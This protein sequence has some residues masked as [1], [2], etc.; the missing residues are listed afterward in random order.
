MRNKG[1]LM[2]G[3]IMLY[4]AALIVINGSAVSVSA[5]SLPV[6]VGDFTCISQL[7]ELP[8]G[9]EITAMTMLL[10]Y[11]G[12][13]M[14]KEM[15]AREYLPVLKEFQE[16]TARSGKHG[17][18]TVTYGSDLENYFLGDPFTEYGTV[19]GTSAIVMAANLYLLETE[20]ELWAVDRSGITAKELYEIVL[21]GNPAVVF[22][23]IDMEDRTETM[24]WYTEDGTYVEWSHNDH[25]TVIIG[26]SEQKVV[27]ADPLKGIVTYDKEQFEKIFAQ[28]GYR[29]VVIKE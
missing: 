10:N 19:C 7:P 20:R 5:K 22:T 8:T 15:M 4:M 16:G 18:G 17:R 23:T 9:C 26:C 29:C 27:I 6:T 21:A 24:G 12:C 28:R 14:T 3:M 1:K 2:K 13:D 11:Y 25:A